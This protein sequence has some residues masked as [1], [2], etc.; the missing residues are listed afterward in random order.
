LSSL[1]PPYN[2]YPNKKFIKS[3]INLV[4]DSHIKT[5]KR[6]GSGGSLLEVLR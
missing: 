1:I 6:T 3:K 5:K 2:E 4:N